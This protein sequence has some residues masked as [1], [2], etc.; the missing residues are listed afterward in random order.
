MALCDWLCE[1]QLDS[2]F[3]WSWKTFRV[4]K[5]WLLTTWQLQP[6][7]PTMHRSVETEKVIK[8]LKW[9]E[10]LAPLHFE[11][12]MTSDEERRRRLRRPARVLLFRF[13]CILETLG[14]LNTVGGII[15]TCALAAKLRAVQERRV[16]WW[17]LSQGR[18]S[19]S[20]SFCCLIRLHQDRP[21]GV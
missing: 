21:T 7:P 6:Q 1:F 13:C 16:S 19:L 10:S 18:L 14:L 3:F 11:F 20:L 12:V 2:F 15:I 5:C 8:L 9:C 4:K 17:K